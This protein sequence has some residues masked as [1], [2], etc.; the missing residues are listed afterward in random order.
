VISNRVLF[1]S[2]TLCV[3][4]EQVRTVLLRQPTYSMGAVDSVGIQV[5]HGN[6]RI[7]PRGKLVKFTGN[8]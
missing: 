2:C 6:L 8:C 5:K 1:M 3:A 4:E 7:N